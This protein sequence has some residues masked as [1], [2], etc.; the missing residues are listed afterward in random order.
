M[1]IT[2]ENKIKYLL[3]DNY[4]PNDN[5]SYKKVG[6]KETLNSMQLHHFSG[7]LS[8]QFTDDKTKTREAT[9]TTITV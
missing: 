1:F 9:A 6:N 8:L 5:N 3:D 4:Q 2:V 7:I